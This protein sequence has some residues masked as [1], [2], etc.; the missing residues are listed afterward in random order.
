MNILGSAFDTIS[1]VSKSLAETL[2][3]DSN[4]MNEKEEKKS[5][6]H[7]NIRKCPAC[8]ALIPALTIA[9]NECGYEFSGIEK[10]SSKKLSE[11]LS[12]ASFFE[13][14][15]KIIKNFPIPNTKEDLFELLIFLKPEVESYIYNDED[16]DYDVYYKKYKEC[17]EKIRFL[18]SNDKQF[19]PF[20]EE[21]NEHKKRIKEQK[22]KERIEI[23]R[24][25]KREKMTSRIFAIIGIVG[26]ICL[27]ASSIIFDWWLILLIIIGSIFLIIII[28]ALFTL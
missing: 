1:K 5:E 21:F 17:M 8:G 20:I 14:K 19:A 9:C 22:E 26:A 27:I 11:L 6:K 10:T 4:N 3:S 15:E 23:E 13:N 24:E 28:I 7:G 16:A 25:E 18:C 2:D 12:K